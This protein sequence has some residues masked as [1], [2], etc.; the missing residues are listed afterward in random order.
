[1]C[2]LIFEGTVPPFAGVTPSSFILGPPSQGV[3]G[4][5]LLVTDSSSRNVKTVPSSEGME[6]LKFVHKV[7]KAYQI[8][9]KFIRTCGWFFRS[10][11]FFKGSCKKFVCILG[12]VRF[13][14]LCVRTTWKCI[15]IFGFRF[16]YYLRFLRSWKF[17][18]KLKNASMEWDEVY[19]I[20][21]HCFVRFTVLFTCYNSSFGSC[22][23]TWNLRITRVAPSS[24]TDNIAE[25]ETR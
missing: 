23:E 17:V 9:K 12:E 16:S 21:V 8:F 14:F 6:I 3:M 22:L 1:M 2:V 11:S 10:H 7:W 4:D 13:W 18:Q 15:R 19:K 20:R 25:V 5:T 24:Q